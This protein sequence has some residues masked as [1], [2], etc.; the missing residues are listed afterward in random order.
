ML[1]TLVHYIDPRNILN[2]AALKQFIISNSIIGTTVGVVVAYASWDLVRS[3]VGDILLPG[4]W[5]LFI[6]RFVGDNSF[7]T[8]VFEPVNKMNVPKFMKEF[9]SFCII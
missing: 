7:F 2:I 9:I 5:F 6:H 4:V 8:N 3:L 1:E